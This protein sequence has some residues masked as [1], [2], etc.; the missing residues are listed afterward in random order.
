MT[1]KGAHMTILE[2]W[3][4]P[5]SRV[6]RTRPRRAVAV[7]PGGGAVAYR[8]TG[9]R[10]SR[11]P[12]RPRPVSLRMTVMLAAL[13]ALVTFWLIALA[14]ARSADTAS[15][16]VPEQLGVVYVQPGENLQRL[17]SRVS[18]DAPVARVVERIRELNELDS[19]ALDAG[20]TLIAPIG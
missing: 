20:Q 8:G 13:A 7:R 12:H 18:P 16:K 14:Q 5:A 10:M 19:A 2:T 6:E 11:A 9:V 1:A 17:A 3:E 4:R 15:T